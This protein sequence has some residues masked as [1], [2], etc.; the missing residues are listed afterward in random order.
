MTDT[1]RERHAAHEAGHA[2]V[3]VALGLSLDVVSLRRGKCFTAVTMFAPPPRGPMSGGLAV[4]PRVADRDAEERM[5]LVTLAGDLAEPYREPVAG[6]VEPTDDEVAARAAVEALERRSP[7]SAELLMAA[8]AN[9]GLRNDRIHAHDRSWSL[10]GYA[11]RVVDP[12]LGY[13]GAIARELVVHHLFAIRAVARELVVKTV[14]DGPEVEA[15][16]RSQR[17]ICH[18]DWGQPAAPAAGTPE[19][20]RAMPPKTPMEPAAVYVACKTGAAEVDGND[21]LI[22]AGRTRIPAGHPVR[23]AIPSYFEPDATGGPLV[24]PATRPRYVQPVDPIR[25][26]EPIPS[27]RRVRA[28]RYVVVN[29]V[30]LAAVGQLFDSASGLAQAIERELP[31]VLVPEPDEPV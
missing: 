4:W 26:L 30:Q 13:L 16:I 31:G 23:Q 24:E 1:G 5:I 3:A 12:F 8:E 14:I 22:E 18:R 19:R 29:G 10:H 7:R 15:I 25:L 28:T 20:S 11:E 6:Y 21:V 2:A 27:E 9:E 17:C